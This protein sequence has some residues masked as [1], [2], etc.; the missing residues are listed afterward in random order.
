[1]ERHRAAHVD[2]QDGTV[3]LALIVDFM[4]PTVVEEN[5][6]SFFPPVSLV[7]QPDRRRVFLRH[8]QAEVITELAPV[9]TVMRR[10]R[11]TLFQN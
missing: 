11:L 7:L 5:A 6:L 2:D 3:F 8:K 4:I 10:D 1:L 9:G